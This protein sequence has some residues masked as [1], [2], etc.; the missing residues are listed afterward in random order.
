MKYLKNIDL[1]K[2]EYL[3]LIKNKLPQAIDKCK[4]DF[5]IYN[6]RTDIYKG[7]LLGRLSVSTEGIIKS[8]ELVFKYAIDRNIP[9]LML[10]SGGYSKKSAEITGK[11]IENILQ[12]YLK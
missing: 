12:K 10:L 8:D 11:F 2:Q 7:D 5:I 9:V 6:A 1:T 4:P 3:L